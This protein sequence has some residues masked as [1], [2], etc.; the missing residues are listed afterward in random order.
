MPRIA[1]TSRGPALALLL[2]L[3]APATLRALGG[4]AFITTAQDGDWSDPAVWTG[5]VLPTGADVA[6][7]DHDVVVTQP[8]A[9]ALS[10]LVGGVSQGRLDVLSGDLFTQQLTVGAASAGFLVVDGGTVSTGDLLVATASG[11]SGQ[12]QFASGLVD[13]ENL[14][15]GGPLATLGQIVVT[16][17]DV[18]VFADG[19][20]FVNAAGTLRLTPTALDASGLQPIVAGD[21][22][23]TAGST[24]TVAVSSLDPLVGQGWDIVEVGGVVTGSPSTVD[25][26][27][28]YTVQL[29]ETP[30]GLRAVVTDVPS[31][32]D[33][34]GASTVGA[35]VVLDAQG[36]LT[37]VSPLNVTVTGAQAPLALAWL[38]LS[39]VPFPALGGT[40][41]A[42]P[43]TNQF[44]LDTSAGD[45]VISTT[46]PGGIPAGMT[47][48]LQVIAQDGS[49]PDG[50]VLSN[51]ERGTTH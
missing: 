5:G 38:S 6:Q 28:S 49:V 40:V 41:H 22:T 46:W 18:E 35:P 15:V 48:V 21:V 26:P 32:V 20:L 37:P 9:T 12:A 2:L 24:L 50:L 10:V 25:A 7:V 17:G 36:G 27:G 30:P 19:G 14:V 1:R 23:F 3:V 4:G 44:L 8:G 39:P 43:F 16:G 47:F 34:G 42:F 51:A 13:S 31:F 45:V 33:L 29:V 11:A